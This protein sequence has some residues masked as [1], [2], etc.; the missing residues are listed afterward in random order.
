MRKD[1][2][3]DGVRILGHQESNQVLPWSTLLSEVS[4]TYIHM[5]R[6]Q[7]PE[8]DSDINLLCQLSL[9]T[10]FLPSTKNK[11]IFEVLS[12]PGLENNRH[13]ESKV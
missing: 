9:D 1:E 10:S 6:G 2:F 8:V 13:W 4:I 3:K 11:K 12:C 5:L 7:V